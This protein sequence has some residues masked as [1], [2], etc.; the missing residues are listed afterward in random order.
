MDQHQSSL[1]LGA[2]GILSAVLAAASATS[3][4]Q[5]LTPQQA[6]Q[7]MAAA[8]EVLA[9]QKTMDS[10]GKVCGGEAAKLG[11]LWGE[12]N[13]P[14]VAKALELRSAVL[15]D[16]EKSKGADTAKAFEAKQNRFVADKVAIAVREVQS[17]PREKKRHVCGR[18]LQT[19]NEGQ[20]DVANDARLYKFLMNAK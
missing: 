6:G 12:R 13:K 10:V 16:V 19:V 9:A 14:A 20:W 3:A 8:G 7:Y 18:Y 17:L 4:A 15:R 1:R 11:A 5:E 2:A